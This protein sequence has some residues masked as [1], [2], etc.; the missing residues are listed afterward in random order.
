[1]HLVYILLLE[2]LQPGTGVAVVVV[3]GHTIKP[4]QQ[5]VHSNVKRWHCA[6]VGAAL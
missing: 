2:P 1:M 5:P 3:M 6:R 4:L